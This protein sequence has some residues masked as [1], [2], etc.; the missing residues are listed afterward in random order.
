MFMFTCINA[1]VFQFFQKY[2]YEVE[3]HIVMLD[4]I[5]D[6]R[7][8]STVGNGSMFE[9]ITNCEVFKVIPAHNCNPPKT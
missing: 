4:V 9:F 5:L 3:I 1:I 6:C 7:K 8:V 2:K